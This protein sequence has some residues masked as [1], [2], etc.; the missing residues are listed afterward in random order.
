MKEV[1]TS[2]NLTAADAPL[3]NTPEHHGPVVSV[4]TWLLV[5][6]TVFVMLARVVTRYATM[7]TLRS[8]D[9]LATFAMVRTLSPSLYHRH[10]LKLIRELTS[11]CIPGHCY[12]AIHCSFFL[13]DTWARLLRRQPQSRSAGSDP[14]GAS[15][16]QK[17][18]KL[19]RA[20][21]SDTSRRPS[22]R[23]S[24]SMLSLWV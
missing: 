20:I 7:K 16:P 23:V 4:V 2:T 5:I 6:T 17:R 14:K 21:S 1:I 9:I 13:V 24:C 19:H 18:N 15:L 8:D 3:W 11:P 10:C 12:R 22:T